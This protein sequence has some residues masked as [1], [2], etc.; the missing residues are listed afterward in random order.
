MNK[1]KSP[2][3]VDFLADCSTNVFFLTDLRGLR[4]KRYT[5]SCKNVTSITDD[6]ILSAY[7]TALHTDILCVWQR[8]AV[9]GVSVDSVGAHLL[10]CPKE[11]ILFWSGEKPNLNDTLSS[12][13]QEV[14][15]G[16]YEDGLSEEI[17]ELFF[18]SLHNMIEKYLTEN[19]FVRLGKWFVSP[20]KNDANNNSSVFSS[21]A[22]SFSLFL[23]GETSVVASINVQEKT[24]IR[25]LS[26]KDLHMSTL[27]MS[28]ESHVLLAPYGLNAQLTG[29][30]LG[31]SDT[32]SLKILEE[33]QRFFPS[34]PALSTFGQPNVVEVVLGDIKML[35]PAKL[36]LIPSSSLSGNNAK[37]TQEKYD[38]I[39][40]TSII[41]NIWK[42]TQVKQSQQTWNF[43]E[44]NVYT[45]CKCM[46]A[47][48]VQQSSND[49]RM[50]FS[51]TTKLTS[52]Q[53]VKDSKGASIFHYR[54]QKDISF[55][56]ERLTPLL[57]CH[58]AN[59]ST[60]KFTA[61]D[62]VLEKNISSNCKN[63]KNV[64]KGSSPSCVNKTN[65]D[66]F[67][68][69]PWRISN[70]L[71][72]F[73]FKLPTSLNK[74]V[75]TLSPLDARVINEQDNKV[76]QS[77]ISIDLPVAESDKTENNT[78]IK[79]EHSDHSEP[80]VCKNV[81]VETIEPSKRGPGRPRGRQNSLQLV[82]SNF[83]S[84]EDEMI[85]PS[86]NRSSSRSA[87]RQENMN[88][89]TI[90]C[91]NKSKKTKVTGR[92][93][94]KTPGTP[95]DN[96]IFNF[97]SIKTLPSPL[98][99]STHFSPSIK[100][101]NLMSTKDLMPIS[102]DLDHLFD[103]EDDEEKK[104]SALNPICDPNIISTDGSRL[105]TSGGITTIAGLT[106]QDLVQMYP[107]PPS[108]ESH[109]LSLSPIVS[110]ELSGSCMTIL[111]PDKRHT[112]L[113]TENDQL[114]ITIEPPR[115]K[116]NSPS[117]FIP[118]I[119]FEPI[120]ELYLPVSLPSQNLKSL[121]DKYIKYKS[122]LNFQSPPVLSRCSDEV[123][124]SVNFSPHQQRAEVLP[125]QKSIAL[126]FKQDQSLVVILTL[127]DSFLNWTLSDYLSNSSIQNVT[128]ELYKTYQSVTWN[129]EINTDL[130]SNIV[131]SNKISNEDINDKTVDFSV[132]LIKIL[133]KKFSSTISICHMLTTISQYYS[134]CDEVK[135]SSECSVLLRKNL[136]KRLISLIEY[137]LQKSVRKPL[138]DTTKTEGLLCFKK[139][140]QMS[141][142]SSLQSMSSKSPL[143]FNYDNETISISPDASRHWQVMYLEPFGG[144]R[145][146][147]YI[148]ALPEN[149]FI[150]DSAKRFFKELSS[151][152]ETLNLGSHSPIIKDLRDGM[153]RI[154]QKDYSKFSAVTVDEWFEGDARAQLKFVAQFCKHQLGPYLASLSLDSSLYINKFDNDKNNL[155]NCGKQNLVSLSGGQATTINSSTATATVYDDLPVVECEMAI[156][157]IVV[158]MVDPFH[159]N[160]ISKDTNLCSYIGFLRSFLEM[161]SQ[162]NS[163][164]KVNIILQII[165]LEQL[166]QVNSIARKHDTKGSYCA[167]LKRLALNVYSQCRSN[168]TSDV[169]KNQKCMTGFGILNARESLIRRRQVEN[170][171]PTQIYHPAYVLADPMKYVKSD[172]LISS[173]PSSS[174]ENILYCCY[175]LSLDN[176][177]LIVMCTDKIGQLSETTLIKTLHSNKKKDLMWNIILRKLW[178]FINS[179]VSFSVCSWRIVLSR[180][181]DVCHTE[182]KE[183]NNLVQKEIHNLISR[184]ASPHTDVCVRCSTDDSKRGKCVFRSIS[185]CT[186][187]VD[188]Y[189]RLMLFKKIRNID[190]AYSRIYII[191]SSNGQKQTLGTNINDSFS[192]DRKN[193]LFNDYDENHTFMPLISS[194]ADAS[195]FSTSPQSEFSK[196]NT[197]GLSPPNIIA[198]HNLPFF[199]P[200]GQVSN[201]Y[202]SPNKHSNKLCNQLASGFL[203]SGSSDDKQKSTEPS[204][205]RSDL[206]IHESSS[207][208]DLTHPLDS[209]NFFEVLRFILE[210]FDNLS[211]LTINPATGK[212]ESSFP[213]HVKN[214]ENC[215]K[216]LACFT[217]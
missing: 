21:L 132:D 30:N 162:L 111:S 118:K 194:P 93:E 215:R 5:C 205:L 25:H 90:D 142:K 120:S 146:I 18:R 22:F 10:K 32:G 152:Y 52:T 135:T 139:L 178:D 74:P 183:M 79:N 19:E 108:H 213:V 107:T 160:S 4:W 61:P 85:S 141:S 200:L 150:V 109:N 189:I 56:K 3:N 198:G 35:Y 157:S 12:N 134:N 124:S 121:S 96:Q 193:R 101:K 158:Y 34:V 197:L 110:N 36:V 53:S 186:T 181:G 51:N 20:L 31:E 211:W 217:C 47:T 84:S 41:K 2:E 126:N 195:L 42:M 62:T 59:S 203:L 43:N 155:S 80:F 95:N 49:N 68:S 89:P 29:H 144:Q 164:L 214:V 187:K 129:S 98:T 37:H 172:S 91:V 102:D 114:E 82:A 137:G 176:K 65:C 39:S 133:L 112:K 170:I 66:T 191:P 1:L 94:L 209:K 54:K 44:N 167:E 136:V 15:Y 192:T 117:F 116:W 23:H 113:I 127:F 159:N 171:L 88:S 9:H 166:L 11:L 75:I 81:K 78:K 26:A 140:Y 188:R 17:L 69:K 122:T 14:G 149:D 104:F 60:A 125:N 77:P 130:Y 204:V 45:N 103:E 72:P 105:I 206:L 154:K 138:W 76:T 48:N 27:P 165:P 174:H 97:S 180:Y 83:Q 115:F 179:V 207:A 24:S 202:I 210:R 153:L 63:E 13:L 6:P 28:S 40:A 151:I 145:N 71:K 131:P 169:F 177:W 38:H 58:V 201:S 147:A 7:S 92:G 156:P 163:K 106:Q 173:T 46:A 55:I 182:L 8:V 57:S 196:M 87:K 161:T 128:Y 199:S 212:R 123:L 119:C 73:S 99:P 143:L 190:S 184:P 185:F 86:G 33:W 16:A 50:M 100:T 168:P 67:P 148:V 175:C 216:I 208:I 70:N 64:K